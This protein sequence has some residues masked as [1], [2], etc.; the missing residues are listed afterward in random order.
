MGQK[1]VTYIKGQIK[2]ALLLTPGMLKFL[3]IRAGCDILDSHW[4]TGVGLE[5]FSHRRNRRKTPTVGWGAVNIL[6]K[7]RY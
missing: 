4:E 6:N 3:N 1:Q 7:Q 5:T 2:S